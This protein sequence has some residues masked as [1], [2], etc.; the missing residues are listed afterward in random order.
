MVRISIDELT[1]K[2]N[3][4]FEALDVPMEEA[5]IITDTIL[6]AHRCEVH[7]HGVGRMHIYRRKIKENLLLAKSNLQELSSMGMTKVF[8]ANNGFGQVAAYKAM[9][10]AIENAKISGVGISTVR[11]SN[12]FGTAAYFGRLATDQNMI[13]M[14]FANSAPAIAPTN[15]TKPILGTNPV[16]FAFPTNDNIPVILDMAT[17]IVA[18][19]KIRLADK[20]NRDIPLGWAYDKD[21]NPTTSPSEAIKGSLVPIGLYKGY[22]LS[23]VVDILAGVLAGSAFGGDVKNLN[24]PT[25]KSRN[26]HFIVAINPEFFSSMDNYFDMIAELKANIKAC[27]EE[28]SIFTPGEI[29][30]RKYL[31]NVEFVQVPKVQME[32]LNK[33][34]SELGIN[35]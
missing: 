24:H 14:I 3:A 4:I 1:K 32:E 35:L 29:E 10:S 31:K 30:G 28:G 21:G 9:N 11:N 27:G 12:N 2:L 5:E 20:E 15:G 33:I 22:G 6:Y 25:D 18:R 34:L 8:D 23:L 19:G 16:C 7:T 13:G 17:S 26:G